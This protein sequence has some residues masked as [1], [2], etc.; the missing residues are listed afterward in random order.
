M[1]KP[2]TREQQQMLAAAHDKRSS[3]DHALDEICKLRVEVRVLTANAKQAAQEDNPMNDTQRTAEDIVQDADAMEQALRCELA[4]RLNSLGLGEGARVRYRTGLRRRRLTCRKQKVEGGIWDLWAEGP[5]QSAHKWRSFW[6]SKD[7]V[8][9][10]PN[11]TVARLLRHWPKIVAARDR[12]LAKRHKQLA[13]AFDAM[14]MSQDR[15]VLLSD[16][17]KKAK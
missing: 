6:S 2:L 11:S 9:G 5:V 13:R 16:W 8:P 15:K 4:K 1:S 3:Y 10:V 7:D 17:L 14:V 12:A